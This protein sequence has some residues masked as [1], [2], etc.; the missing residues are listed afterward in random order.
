MFGQ[1]KLSPSFTSATD[2]NL[3]R[4]DPEA[5][6]HLPSHSVVVAVLGSLSLE[7][8][9]LSQI[10]GNDKYFD[11]IQRVIN[12]LEKWQSKTSLPGMWPAMV[13]STKFNQGIAIGSPFD[14]TDELFTLGALADSTYEYLPKASPLECFSP[15][16]C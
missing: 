5:H 3:Y 6:N 12:E 7:F 15:V 9:R 14:N 4:T 2:T 1:R 13:D 10:T 11:G 16:L 8:T